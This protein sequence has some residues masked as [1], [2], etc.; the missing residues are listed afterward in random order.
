MRVAG[1]RSSLRRSSRSRPFSCAWTWESTYRLHRTDSGLGKEI[2]IPHVPGPPKPDPVEVIEVGEAPVPFLRPFDWVSTALRSFRERPLP[3]T[4]I[5]QAAP[6]FDLFGTSQLP[7]YAI[8]IINGGVG[9]IEVTGAR[10]PATKWRQYLSVSV[11]HDD[12]IALHRMLF[13]RVV[14]DDTAGFPAIPFESSDALSAAEVFTARNISV[15]PDGRISASVAAI[16]VGAQLH[17]R[18]LFIEYDIGE[19]SGDVS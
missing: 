10:V 18:T 7:N 15:P 14:Q 8:E 3:G 1:T 13:S 9:N 17:L 5:T 16:G 2:A 19:P 6:G 12:G 11:S 4:Y